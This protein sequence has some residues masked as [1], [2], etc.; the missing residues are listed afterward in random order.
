MKTDT[1]EQKVITNTAKRIVE[2]LMRV[3]VGLRAMAALDAA[4]NKGEHFPQAGQVIGHHA[5]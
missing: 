3:E 5:H 4:S 1:L 2:D